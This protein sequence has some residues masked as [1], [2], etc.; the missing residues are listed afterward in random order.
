MTALACDVPPPPSELA[1]K[2]FRSMLDFSSRVRSIPWL[3]EQMKMKATNRSHAVGTQ[4]KVG[5]QKVPCETRLL[6]FLTSK[7][8]YGDIACL[9][10]C[11]MCTKDMKI[12]YNGTKWR[13]RRLIYTLCTPASSTGMPTGILTHE[14]SSARSKHL[15]LEHDED[16]VDDP[17]ADNEYEDADVGSNATDADDVGDE[18]DPEKS[19]RRSMHG[20]S[21][22]KSECI[23]PLHQRHEPLKVRAKNKHGTTAVTESMLRRHYP[24][25]VAQR[26]A[27]A[28]PIYKR[29]VMHDLFAVIPH[30]ISVLK[31][32]KKSILKRKF[33]T[34]QCVGRSMLAA[35]AAAG[36]P[37]LINAY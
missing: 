9:D 10:D 21:F 1:K 23:N 30:H 36:A 26:A 29:P 31:T 32:P 33:Y 35:A 3:I 24:A 4:R 18:C 22:E 5:R 17:D 19:A 37:P 12:W 15:E 6:S 8:V 25:A 11:I 16:N 7:K 34:R 27:L 28:A 2:D 20:C 14:N 13:V